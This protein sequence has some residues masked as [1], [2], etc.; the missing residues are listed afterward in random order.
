MTTLFVLHRSD[1]TRW[2]LAFKL[3]RSGDAV[4]LIQDG[5]I[6]AESASGDSGIENL[7]KRGI[8]TLAVKADVDTR[9]INIKHGVECIDYDQLVDLLIR[10]DRS[11][12]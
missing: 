4:V 2:D 8:R 11:F 5:V 6:A 9:R 12:S 1:P 3:A 7:A 10:Y